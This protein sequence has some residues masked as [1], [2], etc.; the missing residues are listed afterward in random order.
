[1]EGRLMN[2]I[3]AVRESTLWNTLQ[4]QNLNLITTNLNSYSHE[5]FA[6]YFAE[7]ILLN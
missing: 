4:S 6:R 1:M 7:Q 2:H 3:L 5:A